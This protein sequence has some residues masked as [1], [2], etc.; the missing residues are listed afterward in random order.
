MN[1]FFFVLIT[2][3][4]WVA[5]AQVGIET[6]NVDPS[7]I[8]EINSNNFA[9]GNKKGFLG[10]KVNLNS[11]TDTQT[12]PSP[13]VGLLIYNLIDAGTYPNEVYANR[14]YYWNGTRWSN[15]G[16]TN[17]LETYLSNRTIS[18]NSTSNQ[19]FNYADINATSASNG[20]LPVSFQD[21]DVV[22]NTGNIA[23]RTG[24][25]TFTIN[26]TGLYEISG[27]VNYNPN[28]TTIGSP[29]RGCALNIK[30]QLS[31]NNGSTW[32]DV[33][34][35]RTLWGIRTNN[36]AK[37]VLLIST[38]LNLTRGQLLRMVVQNPFAL[39]D[40]SSIHGE[41]PSTSPTAPLPAI[42]TSTKNPISKNLTLT[43]LDYDIQ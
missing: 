26:I 1:K 25:T 23:T 39:S 33:I 43:L 22:I 15:I 36:L 34:G 27:F 35:N 31:N 41:N 32:T 9:N 42:V 2:C 13:A 11:A 4:V 29:Q 20:G 21:T 10:P 40:A 24:T 7:A 19:T 12:I 3:F 14:F 37:T 18:F 16:T 38:P 28:R 6:S 8:L 30:L 17:L 5:N